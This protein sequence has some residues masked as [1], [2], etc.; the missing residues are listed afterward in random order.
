MRLKNVAMLK[1][2][3]LHARAFESVRLAPLYDTL[4]TRVFP[5]LHND[6]MALKLAE[7]D[8]QLRW[9]DFETCT[10]TIDL[11]LRKAR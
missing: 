4:T 5:E 7:K 2:A 1:M 11:P 6:R 10:P 3:A 9:A 8:N